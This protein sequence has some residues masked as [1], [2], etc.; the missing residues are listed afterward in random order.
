MGG[1]LG[2]NRNHRTGTKAKLTP[3]QVRRQHKIMCTHPEEGSS[4]VNTSTKGSSDVEGG[5]GGG[6]PGEDNIMLGFQNLSISCDDPPEHIVANVSGYVV[7][8][9]R[10]EIILRF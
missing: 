10:G 3:G 9:T 6:D 8:G 4:D 2:A 5:G 7:K 1:V